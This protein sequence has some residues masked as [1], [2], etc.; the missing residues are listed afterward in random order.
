MAASESHRERV[1]GLVVFGGYADIVET[2]RFCIV[3]E[4]GFAHDPLNRPVVFINLLDRVRG[5]PPDPTRVLAQW[6]AYVRRTWGHPELKERS[7]FEPIARELARAL[8]D[9]ERESFLVG[10]GIGDD[11]DAIALEALDGS[12]EFL[13]TLDPRPHLDGLRCPVHVV[14]GRDDDVIPYTQAERLRAA[15][16]AHVDAEVRVTGLYAHTG[17]TGLRAWLGKL[18][19]LAGELRALLGI[20]HA[21]DRTA[22]SRS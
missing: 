1:A 9:D 2:I 7:R 21:I 13:A 15:L 6:D 14:H 4:P 19:L 11:A 16:P 22:R 8:P 17:T 3:G 10:C 12:H 5:L 20:L 18:R